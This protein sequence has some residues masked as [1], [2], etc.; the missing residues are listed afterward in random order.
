[1]IE[2]SGRIPE[3]FSGSGYASLGDFDKCQQLTWTNYNGDNQIASYCLIS[4][5]PDNQNYD[6]NIFTHHKL[7][8]PENGN[9]I[10]IGL[11][12]PADCSTNDLQIIT[13]N[14]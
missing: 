5:L 14:G 3:Q 11:C 1:M 8:S 4:L 10:K 2:T 12:L 7:I 9:S 6:D 13:I